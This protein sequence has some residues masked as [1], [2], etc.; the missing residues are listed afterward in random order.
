MRWLLALMATALLAPSSADAAT[1][2]LPPLL[3]SGVDGKDAVNITQLVSSELDFSPSVDELIELQTRPATLDQRCLTSTGCLGGIAADNGGEQVLAGE[4]AAQG[5]GFG[6]TLVLFD[7]ASNR[8]VRNKTFN[9]PND[10]TALANGMTDVVR[11]MMTGAGADAAPAAAAAGLSDFDDLPEEEDDFAFDEAANAAEMAAAQAAAVQLA[12]QQAAQQAAAKR[13]AEEAAQ[14]AAEEAAR[15]AAEEEAR[16]LAELQRV[17]EEQARLAAEQRRL[18]EEERQRRAAEAALIAAAAASAAAA[19]TSDEDAAAMIS[20]GGSADDISAEEI[21]QL[22]QFG[23]P[24]RTPPPQPVAQPLP[25]PAN[26]FA[27]EEAE[28]QRA[29]PIAAT[30]EPKQ[31]REPKPKA[32]KAPKEPREKPTKSAATV[33]YEGAQYAQ[34]TLRGGY[35]KYYA[36]DFFTGGGE[37]AVPLGGGVHAMA[38]LELY[39]V[40]RLVPEDL[41]PEVGL[42]TEWNTILPANFGLLYKFTGNLVQPY[43]GGDIIVVQYYQ[44]EIGSDWAAGARLRGGADFMFTDNIG[45]NLNAA[46]GAWNGKNWYLIEENVQNTGL[47]P[48]IS[49]GTVVAF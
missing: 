49:A 35:S 14:R 4:L 23:A 25:A 30:D 13:A 41:A 18:E 3:Q 27:A 21:D 40:K 28:L 44:D 31:K 26:D 32:E 43:V 29:Q 24:T 15:Q 33:D 38:G 5:E 47:L 11:E 42:L 17:Q 1:V 45:L 37:I 6:L 48:Q 19:A 12:A 36:F 8:I 46:V 10:P 22:I 7:S 20:F 39:G 34:L 16:R 2:V 9:L